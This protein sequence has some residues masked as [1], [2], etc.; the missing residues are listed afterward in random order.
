MTYINSLCADVGTAN[1]P[2]I[3]ASTGDCLVCSRLAG[4]DECDCRWSGVC[5]YNEYVQNGSIVREKRENIY[6]K[7]LKKTWY[8]NDLLV[9]ALKVSKGFALKASQPGSFI[10]VNSDRNSEF[11]NVPVSVMRSDADNGR[12]FVALK[13]ISG[14]TKKVAEEQERLSVRGVYRNGLLGGGLSGMFSDIKSAGLEGEKR[15]W[16]IITKGVGFAPAVNIT[17]NAND[18][19]EL[20]FVVDTEKIG[21]EIIE[22]YLRPGL[23]GSRQA[24]LFKGSLA[25]MTETLIAE[26]LRGRTRLLGGRYNTDMY[27]RIM[28]M[29][30]DYYIRTL[31]E[32]M[33][34]PGHK[35]VF[36]NN[37]KMCCGE[38]IC[39]ACGHIDKEG[40]VNKM[41]KCR[42][43]DI[44]ELL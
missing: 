29:A 36:C 16:L 14:K 17:E 40:H 22:D 21:E 10:F 6:S 42:E 9:M 24:D 35:L 3:L 44:R 32:N 37:F 18:N 34:I 2:C 25:S 15:K 5:I 33:E 38:G 8:G 7:I 43:A 39:G 31:A 4:R 19:I 28:I 30:S 27:D 20:D 23:A 12:I 1:C 26:R 13:I 11:S 41:C